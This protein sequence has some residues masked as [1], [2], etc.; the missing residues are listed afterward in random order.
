MFR[1]AAMAARALATRPPAPPPSADNHVSVSSPLTEP[2][3]GNGDHSAFLFKPNV[4][5]PAIADPDINL[6]SNARDHLPLQHP[7]D[8]L[9]HMPA[10][11]DDNM[12]NGAQPPHP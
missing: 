12:S 2:L 11:L 6:V 1:A 3:S 5:H 7:A 4:D 10:G 9:L 8:N